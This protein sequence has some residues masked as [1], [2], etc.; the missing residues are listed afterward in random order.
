MKRQYSK[1]RR[2]SRSVRRRKS[3]NQRRQKQKTYKRYKRGGVMPPSREIPI[4]LR[5]SLATFGASINDAINGANGRWSTDFTVCDDQICKMKVSASNDEVNQGVMSN[6]VQ[7]L[8]QKMREINADLEARTEGP[9][10]ISNL[11][12]LEITREDVRRMF[13][14][15]G[16]HYLYYDME[17][18]IEYWDDAIH[19]LIVYSPNLR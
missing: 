5:Q 7:N 3:R 4:E 14:D 13:Q 1:R 12:V 8:Q 10:L 17:E 9:L 2:M 11:E 16:V 18:D 6:F 19:K 15:P